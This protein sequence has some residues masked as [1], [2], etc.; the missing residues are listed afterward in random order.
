MFGHSVY[1]QKQYSQEETLKPHL[2][3]V[4]ICSHTYTHSY[5]VY[6]Q[7]GNFYSRRASQYLWWLLFRV[8]SSCFSTCRPTV[9]IYEY[10]H[11]LA[12]DVESL[13]LIKRLVLLLRL[14]MLAIVYV[15]KPENIRFSLNRNPSHQPSIVDFSL[16]KL[17][18]YSC[19]PVFYIRIIYGDRNFML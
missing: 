16:R 8:S 7:F 13:V 15:A 6:K 11:T 12:P 19:S 9:R 5:A 2:S 14:T 10:A 1:I 18:N 4:I 3:R 17:I